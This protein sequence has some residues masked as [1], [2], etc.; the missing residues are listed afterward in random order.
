MGT[1]TGNCT[2]GS[3]R[4]LKCDIH[5]VWLWLDLW[6]W[7]C[8]S[9]LEGSQQRPSGHSASQHAVSITAVIM[10]PALSRYCENHEIS[11]YFGAHVHAFVSQHTNNALQVAAWLLP[12]L[13]DYDGVQC[14]V[15]SC[16]AAQDKN[17]PAIPT[18]E[19]YLE[20]NYIQVH[21][22]ETKL[23]QLS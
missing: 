14:A 1:Q 19:T 6:I 11:A 21:L 4:S 17:Q 5:A 16:T 23:H 15:W 10:I 18:V 9:K 22:P 7:Q 12:L 3:V 20:V 13:C 8:P 2:Y